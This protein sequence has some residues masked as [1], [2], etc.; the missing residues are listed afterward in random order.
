MDD[1]LWFVWTGLVGSRLV[2]SRLGLGWLGLGL[3]WLGLGLGRLGLGPRLG[4]LVGS[5][6][7]MGEKNKEKGYAKSITNYC[8][9]DWLVVVISRAGCSFRQDIFRRNPEHGTVSRS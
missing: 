3:G 5:V 1:G 8:A 4:W 6:V 7:V 9:A 2:G